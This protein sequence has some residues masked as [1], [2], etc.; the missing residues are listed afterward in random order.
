MNANQRVI[1]TRNLSRVFKSGEFEVHALSGVD[2][3][4]ERGEFVAVMGSSGS[5]KSTLLHIL[6]CLDKPTS[7]EYFLDGVYV[8]R[9]DEN[10]LAAIRNEKIGFIFQ[11]YN[12]LPRATAL[13]N[14]EL[15][16]MYS[17][18]SKLID[19]DEIARHA[20]ERVGLADRLTH[21][22]KEMSGGQQQRVAIARALVND[23]AIILSDE[24]TGNLDSK[25]SL[26]IAD[27]FVSLN[28]SGKTILMI[29]HE[30][31]IAR[32]SKRIVTF[33]DGRIISDE[34]VINRNSREAALRALDNFQETDETIP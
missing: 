12:L 10:E 22:P 24:A 30:P 18:R 7:G 28:E 15:P 13:E 3:I 5:G 23:P 33:Q 34:P 1:E 31:E 8:N 20:L 16:L 17:R 25:T 6:G 4:V 27:L 26:D 21:K 19:P 32:F 29:T 9:L 2:L 14:V 11:S